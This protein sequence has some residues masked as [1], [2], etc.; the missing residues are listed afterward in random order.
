MLFKSLLRKQ[1]LGYET[2]VWVNLRFWGHP[3]L[4]PVDQETETIVFYLCFRGTN[5]TPSTDKKYHTDT[6][7]T[8]LIHQV[9]IDTKR[10][11]DILIYS[12]PKSS[13]RLSGTSGDPKDLISK[14]YCHTCFYCKLYLG[15]FPFMTQNF[16]M[17]KDTVTLSWN[18]PAIQV[19]AECKH[20][21]N[22]NQGDTEETRRHRDLNDWHP[23]TAQQRESDTWSAG[24][25]VHLLLCSLKLN[26]RPRLVETESQSP[27]K[28]VRCLFLF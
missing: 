11:G 4:T 13:L 19:Q 23:S 22:H 14:H 6:A 5:S 18:D 8:S 15:F 12:V 3:T 17:N 24:K 16:H 10:S 21:H 26:S 27:G 7:T 2:E 20:I 28:K 9:L 1:F 25:R